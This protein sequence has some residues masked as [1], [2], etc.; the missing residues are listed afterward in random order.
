MRKSLVK[1]A[2][3]FVSLLLIFISASGQQPPAPPPPPPP[4][5]KPLAPN[6]PSSNSG[7]GGGGGVTFTTGTQLV[8]EE[9]TVLDKSGKPIEGLTKKDFTLTE[10]GVPQEIQF[11]DN[12]SLP[13]DPGPQLQT[14][15]EK[16]LEVAPL[17]KLTRTAIAPEPPGD[18]QL[19]NRRLMCLYFDMSSM[20][21]ADQLRALSAAEKFVRNMASEDTMAIM[22]YE[23][24]AVEVLSD[25]TDNKEKLLSIIATIIVGEGQGFGETS[26]DAGAADTG[27]AFGQDDSEFNIFTTDR[28]LSAIQ[29]ACKMLGGR[30]EKKALSYFASGLQLNGVDNQAQLHATENSCLKAGV[31]IWPIDSRGLVAT[32]PMGDLN[33]RS[34]GGSGMLTGASSMAYSTRMAQT[35]DTL[36]A[37][38]SD[39]GGKAL[40]DNNDLE[41][42]LENAEK[43]MGSY[44]ILGYYSKNTNLDGKFRKIK[45]T[46]AG[47]N[48]GKLD[49]RPGYYGNKTYNK[50]T[51][52]DKERQLEDALMA[53]D[54][55]T[56]LTMRV[57]MDFFEIN[58]AEYFV[59]M[60]VKI[61][62]S[63]VA[64]AKQ[65]FGGE[66]TVI[67]FIGEVKDDFGGTMQNIRDKADVKISDSTAAELAKR[68]VEYATGFTLLPGKYTVKL[69]ARDAETGRIGTFIQT[70]VIPNLMNEKTRIPIS[71]V[72]LSSQK[73]DLKDASTTLYNAL[74]DKDKAEAAN[75]LVTDGQKLVPSVTRVFN[76]SREMYVYLQ[77]YEQTPQTDVEKDLVAKGLPFPVRPVVAFVTFFKGQTKAYETAPIQVDTPMEPRLKTLPIRFT[78][79]LASLE[80]GEYACQVTVLDPQ[81]Q[82]TAFWQDNVMI[83]P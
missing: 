80:P 33:Q 37:L 17:D 44:Y 9:V 21:Q 63:E 83:V 6:A 54:P 68:P 76:R 82:K 51:T 36:W 50:F 73:A 41:K 79:P 56:E 30:N 67:D 13:A 70:Y 65:R 72:V 4:A 49:Y 75:P 60:M 43:A 32:L 39:T 28:Q 12:E 26:S 10:D 74:K 45:I 3:C 62:G 38:A 69:L 24:S 18:I 46:V 57:E 2:L 42:G 14:R 77:A 71:S 53:G 48:V 61:P 40:L 25:F 29:T 35:Q 59:P 27:A 64:L 16:P 47:D 19:H 7:P 66:H 15:P 1:T 78:V 55:I 23:G 31:Q 34:P 81:G 22:Q 8:V 20:Q 52:A 11:F 5:S 58:R